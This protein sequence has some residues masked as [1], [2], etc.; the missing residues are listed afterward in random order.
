[1]Y[2]YVFLA[3]NC[4]CA[5]EYVVTVYAFQSELEMLQQQIDIG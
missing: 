2:F 4:G 3:D 5:M 1:M